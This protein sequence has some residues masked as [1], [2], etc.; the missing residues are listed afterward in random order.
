MAGPSEEEI[1]AA[2]TESIGNGYA[3]MDVVLDWLRPVM[4]S[5]MALTRAGWVDDFSPGEDHP[6]TFWADLT[7]EET[8]ELQRLLG[9][10]RDRVEREAT[11]MLIDETVAAA[12]AFGK[13]HPD[14]PRG[15]YPLKA[16]VAA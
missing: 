14:I 11:R 3:D 2:L 13:A 5:D 15:R 4:D 9:E 6:G 8:Q 1:R 10:A 12:V 16:T 7:A